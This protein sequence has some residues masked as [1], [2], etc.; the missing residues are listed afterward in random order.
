MVKTQTIKPIIVDN[1]HLYFNHSV[2]S[3]IEA[4]TSA[5]SMVQYQPY[6]DTEGMDLSFNII[7]ESVNMGKALRRAL[8]QNRRECSAEQRE[9]LI[10]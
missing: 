4:Y 5:L 1:L 2:D 10:L 6:R 9:H 7:T 8:E 3:L